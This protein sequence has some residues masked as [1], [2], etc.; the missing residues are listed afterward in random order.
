MPTTLPPCY[1]LRPQQCAVQCSV[2]QTCPVGHKYFTTC[3]QATAAVAVPA[4]AV[5][6]T[7]TRNCPACQRRIQEAAADAKQRVQEDLAHQEAAD[8]A[9]AELAKAQRKVRALRLSC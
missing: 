9:A 7:A 6:T 1:R 4:I 3:L 2:E 5:T 8:A